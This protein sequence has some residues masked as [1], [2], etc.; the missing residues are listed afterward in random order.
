MALQ[1]FPC[2]NPSMWKLKC[3]SLHDKELLRLQMELT[4]LTS[5]LKL[6]RLS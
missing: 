4:F 2:P 1:R 6:R 3:V 5:D